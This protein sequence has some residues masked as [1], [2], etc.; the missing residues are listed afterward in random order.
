[1]ISKNL[2][3]E[4]AGDEFLLQDI[5][6]YA[7][8]IYQEQNLGIQIPELTPFHHFK[9]ARQKMETIHFQILLFPIFTLS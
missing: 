2:K 4:D 6:W 3:P 1:M 9:D 8:V 5:Q 7:R